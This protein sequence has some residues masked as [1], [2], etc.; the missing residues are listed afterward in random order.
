[1]KSLGGFVSGYRDAV[2]A[3]P[4]LT[5]WLLAGPAALI[6]SVLGM[7][8]MPFWVPAGAGDVN[9]IVF[10][11]LL[12]PGIW[13]LAFFYACL[14]ESLPRATTVMLGSIFAQGALIASAFIGG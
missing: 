6:T 4:R 13:A 9:H 2:N 7:A 12:F 3:K 8:A 14:D 1:M 11:I 10:P 5:R